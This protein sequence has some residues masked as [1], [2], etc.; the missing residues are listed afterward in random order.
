M[1]EF[2]SQLILDYHAR[3]SRLPTKEEIAQELHRLAGLLDT[4]AA[5]SK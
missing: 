3:A 2:I 5:K 4:T 1:G